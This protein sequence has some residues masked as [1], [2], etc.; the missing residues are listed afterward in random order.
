MDKIIINRDNNEVSIDLQY[1]KEKYCIEYIQEKK[2]FVIRRLND[3]QIIKVLD[4]NIGF[5]VEYD[6]DS[7][8][9]FF[10]SSYTKT[11]KKENY[12]LSQ[13]TDYYHL[14]DE[15]ILSNEIEVEHLMLND[16]NISDNSAFMSIMQEKNKATR[17]GRFKLGTSSSMIP[18]LTFSFDDLANNLDKLNIINLKFLASEL[19]IQG[20]SKMT[21]S[22][23]KQN[24]KELLLTTKTKGT[25][26]INNCFSNTSPD[27]NKLWS[28]DEFVEKYQS[29]GSQ[30]VKK[31]K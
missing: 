22:E 8:S 10:V 21:I 31:Y 18:S 1:D 13:Y 24:I 4:N 20:R 12:K 19:F 16:F 27:S 28:V 14:C 5:I 23:L 29:K 15:L 6:E 2:A 9:N 26:D 7:N 30:K 11:E 17:Y 3:G 25:L